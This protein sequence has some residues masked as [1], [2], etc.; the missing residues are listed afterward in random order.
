VKLLLIIGIAVL[1]V[2]AG[3]IA[4]VVLLNNS[5]GDEF[6]EIGD[7]AV[8]SVMY[9]LGEK[10]KISSFSKSTSR[11]TDKIV[12]VYSVDKNQGEEMEEYAQAL[13]DDFDFISVEEYDFGGRRGSDFR[14]VKESDE[15]DELVVLV[16]IDFDSKGYTL[17]ITRGEGTI[18]V[19]ASEESTEE[20]IISED[21]VDDPI[22]TEDPVIEDTPAPTP[23]QTQ[24]PQEDEIDITCP[25]ILLGN[26]VADA[27]AK[28]PSG[29][30][31]VDMTATGDY[32]L[33]M[34]KETQQ[35]A[36]IE[37]M[38]DIEGL[39]T[40]IYN[41]HPGVDDIKWNPDTFN[42]VYLVVNDAFGSDSNQ[43]QSNDALIG[44]ALYAPLVQVYQGEGINAATLIA[45]GDDAME[46]VISEFYSPAV[47]Y[48]LTN[49]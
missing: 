32:I 12:V 48:E 46:N 36:I 11:G 34:T 8:P 45:F 19:G 5:G 14:F 38:A 39:I 27:Q 37:A 10:R 42:I 25:G 9:I 13:V 3:I 17:T 6:F 7:D 15:D 18:N 22:V 44:I 43:Q 41:N 47:L 23:E 29:V 24:A 31:V 35:R 40:D 21:P 33:R 1:V 2:A 26:T 28:V 20:P 30:T 4:A 49:R 16:S